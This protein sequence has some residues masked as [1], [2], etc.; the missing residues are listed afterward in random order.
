MAVVPIPVREEDDKEKKAGFLDGLKGDY[1]TTKDGVPWRLPAMYLGGV[2]GLYGGWKGVDALMSKQRSRD[3][4]DELQQARNEFALAMM[5]PKEDDKKTKAA[6]DNI[7]VKVSEDLSELFALLEK[8]A[9]WGLSPDTWGQLG[10]AYG[11]YAAPTA[12]VAGVAA[13]NAGKKRQRAKILADAIKQ[14]A[15]R[16]QAQQPAELYAMP[17]SESDLLEEE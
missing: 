8:A 4:D 15:L 3:I 5:P 9:S 1:A 2:A 6:A 13:Y 14:R 17:M 12:L 10:G 16:R 7:M 11:M